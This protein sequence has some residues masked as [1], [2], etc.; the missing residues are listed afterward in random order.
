MFLL[1]LL[2]TNLFPTHEVML[3]RDHI[4]I[5]RTNEIVKYHVE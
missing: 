3:H 2:D 4:D 5:R 1:L